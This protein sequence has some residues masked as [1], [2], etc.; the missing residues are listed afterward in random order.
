MALTGWGQA[1]FDENLGVS[2]FYWDL[3]NE[4]TFSQIDLV[5]QCL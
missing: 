3:S 5:G 2:P 4:S 1:K